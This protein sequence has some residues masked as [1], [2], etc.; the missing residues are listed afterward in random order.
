MLK[1]P[2]QPMWLRGGGKGSPQPG[3]PKPGRAGCVQWAGGVWAAWALVGSWEASLDRRMLAQSW[4]GP[5]SLP[6]GEAAQEGCSSLGLWLV[7]CSRGSKITPGRVPGSLPAPGVHSSPTGVPGLNH[8]SVHPQCQVTPPRPCQDPLHQGSCCPH[9]HLW[10]HLHRLSTEQ[11]SLPHTCCHTY[12]SAGMELMQKTWP[13]AAAG[14]PGA[15]SAAAAPWPPP[16]LPPPRG[17]HHRQRLRGTC[18]TQGRG[19]GAVGLWDLQML[20]CGCRSH[21]AQVQKCSPG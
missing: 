2:R 9:A 3:L 6:R 19:A 16:A 7:P 13:C 15:G 21:T 8:M 11:P 14:T 1:L 4:W 18:G 20:S 17:C 5:C 12:S 10:Q